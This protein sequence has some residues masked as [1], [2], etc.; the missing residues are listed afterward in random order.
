MEKNFFFQFFSLPKF[1]KFHS[2]NTGMVVVMIWVREKFSFTWL[3]LYIVFFL[4]F[5]FLPL[6]L[7]FTVL[8]LLYIFRNIFFCKNNILFL[9]KC[10]PQPNACYKMLW[11]F[12]L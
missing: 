11:M 3:F 10:N 6:V 2:T 12:G 7:T 9:L 5:K 8:F 1:D 4:L